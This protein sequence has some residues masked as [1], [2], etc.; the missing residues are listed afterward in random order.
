[1]QNYRQK[2]KPLII[3]AIIMLI[4]SALDDKITHEE[5]YSF[6]VICLLVIPFWIMWDINTRN[7]GKFRLPLYALGTFIGIFGA[8]YMLRE[9]NIDSLLISPLLYSAVFTWL[10]S[11]ADKHQPPE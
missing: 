11:L 8:N 4:F 1:M 10:Q 6:G 5:W 7:A 3:I 9:H 2:L